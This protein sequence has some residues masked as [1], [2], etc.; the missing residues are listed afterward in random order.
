MYALYAKK[1]VPVYGGFLRKTLSHIGSLCMGFNG[2]DFDSF[3][4]CRASMFVRFFFFGWM[5]V[6]GPKCVRWDSNSSPFDIVNPSLESSHSRRPPGY[7]NTQGRIEFCPTVFY[8]QFYFK[9]NINCNKRTI[10]DIKY[11]RWFDFITVILKSQCM[12][13]SCGLTCKLG[14]LQNGLCIVCKLLKSFFHI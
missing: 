14:A 7:S 13:L 12:E 8:L 4:Q 10:Y 11:G 6:P 3:W 5:Y 9:V 1:K 2:V